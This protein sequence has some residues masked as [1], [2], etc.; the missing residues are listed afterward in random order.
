MA[1]KAYGPRDAGPRIT[2]TF[3]QGDHDRVCVVARSKK[4]SAARIVR[5]AAEWKT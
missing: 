1:S 3:P 2:G 4:V 5:N